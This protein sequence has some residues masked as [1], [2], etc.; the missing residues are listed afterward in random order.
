MGNQIE[1]ENKCGCHACI[2]FLNILEVKLGKFLEA[3]DKE[4]TPTMVYAAQDAMQLI[5][6]FNQ[7]EA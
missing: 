7:K 5:R 2:A 6:K 3:S 1:C 4:A